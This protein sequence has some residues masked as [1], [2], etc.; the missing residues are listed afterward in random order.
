MTKCC[1]CLDAEVGLLLQDVPPWELIP[2]PTSHSPFVENFLLLPF[3]SLVPEHSHSPQQQSVDIL[4][5]FPIFHR[6]GIK[7]WEVEMSYPRKE[8]LREI[9][10]CNQK[11]HQQSSPGVWEPQSV[12]EGWREHNYPIKSTHWPKKHLLWEGEPSSVILI[13]LHSLNH[14]LVFSSDTLTCFL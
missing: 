11:W 13:H 7:M 4:G 1:E 6:E 3:T 9:F 14:G 2:L 12:Q 10:M 8:L 5:V